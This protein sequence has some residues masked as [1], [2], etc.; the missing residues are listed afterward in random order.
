M[1]CPMIG[2]LWLILWPLEVC[3]RLSCVVELGMPS[4]K[5][6][7]WSISQNN[8]STFAFLSMHFGKQKINFCAAILQNKIDHLEEPWTSLFFH[9]KYWTREM[10]K[11]AVSDRSMWQESR[12]FFPANSWF[13]W[14]FHNRISTQGSIHEMCKHVTNF[15]INWK[16]FGFFFFFFCLPGGHRSWEKWSVNWLLMAKRSMKSEIS[17]LNGLLWQIPTTSLPFTTGSRQERKSDHQIDWSWLHLDPQ[18]IPDVLRLVQNLFP[19]KQKQKIRSHNRFTH[20]LTF[21]KKQKKEC[22]L[23][24][25]SDQDLDFQEQV[26]LTKRKQ[27]KS[28]IFIILA[29]LNAKRESGNKNV[30][31][32][33]VALCAVNVA[34]RLARRVGKWRHAVS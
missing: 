19:A 30:V 13:I 16:F 33:C 23:R 8:T 11:T 18:Q 27:S 7:H 29:L 9:C 14:L 20:S 1:S 22:I 17:N 2:I 34:L 6:F 12:V 31:T 10:T 4:S 3:R 15:V 32:T 5:H 28:L 26:C 24:L 21:D 25:V